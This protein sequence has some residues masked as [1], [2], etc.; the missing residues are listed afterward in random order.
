MSIMSLELGLNKDK[1]GG[2]NPS[3]Q[4]NFILSQLDLN[5]RVKSSKRKGQHMV[6]I[7]SCDHA[8][9]KGGKYL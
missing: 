6:T 5:W 8:P 3:S 9:S 7:S 4:V 2:Q 1:L